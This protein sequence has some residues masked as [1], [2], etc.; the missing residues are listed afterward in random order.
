MRDRANILEMERDAARMYADRFRLALA[1]V[2]L[3][4]PDSVQ[5]KVAEWALNMR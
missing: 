1:N 3:L 2:M 5:G 4:D